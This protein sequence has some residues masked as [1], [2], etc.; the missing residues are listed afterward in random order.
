M[1]DISKRLDSIE[2]KLKFFADAYTHLHNIFVKGV[3]VSFEK[4]I[5]EP[6][7]SKLT[8]QVYSIGNLIQQLHELTKTG[9]F[10]GTLEFMGKRLNEMQLALSEIKE[11]GINKNIHLDLTMEGY[12]MVKKTKAMK[13]IVPEPPED[14]E[15]ATNFLL[16]TL[17]TREAEVITLRFGLFGHTKKTLDAIAKIMNFTRSRAAQ[18][19]RRALIKLRHPSRKKFVDDLIHKGF[20]KAIKGENHV[21][22]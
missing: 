3:H 4:S 22:N 21:D 5:L 15:E 11:K 9:T 10:L 12:E 20:K 19:E 16:K 17:T 7:L 18:L 1:E 13:D 14:P 8:N 2:Q 6:S